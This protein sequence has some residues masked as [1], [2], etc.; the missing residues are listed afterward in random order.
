MKN[1]VLLHF[2]LFRA[3]VFL[4]ATIALVSCS[5]D[6]E[7][8]TPSVQEVSFRIDLVKFVAQEISDAEGEFLEVYGTVNSK[9]IRDNI[10]EE[11]MIWSVDDEDYVLV[12]AS[13]S[14][15]SSSYT[16]T[17]AE[18][19]IEASSIEVIATLNEYD[20]PGNPDEFLGTRSVTTQL[21]SVSASSTFQMVLDDSDGQV[22]QLTY[23]ITRL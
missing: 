1:C 3:F 15:L 21:S 4:F 10:T 12:G 18:P 20:P 8:D 14:P 16:Y 22:V 7:D 19:N 9:L 2:A 11:N 17:V 13:D 6:D 23:T 5:D